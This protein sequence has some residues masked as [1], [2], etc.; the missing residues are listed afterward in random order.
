MANGE[1]KAPSFELFWVRDRGEN[2]KG[3]W[4]K[5]GAAWENRDGSFSLVFDAYPADGSGRVQMR[6]P[7]EG[8]D[9]KGRDPRGDD[10]GDQGERRDNGRRPSRGGRR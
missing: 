2:E 6:K 7:Y 1:G 4:L 8:D 3:F 5:I 10:G 9:N